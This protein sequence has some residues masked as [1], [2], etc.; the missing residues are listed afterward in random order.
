[1]TTDKDPHYFLPKNA[2]LPLMTTFAAL[3]IS[4][5]SRARYRWNQRCMSP[6]TNPKSS[7]W[8][9]T[10]VPGHAP[11][12]TWYPVKNVYG[13]VNIGSCPNGLVWVEHD[14]G[15]HRYAH[16]TGFSFSPGRFHPTPKNVKVWRWVTAAQAK[17][18]RRT[19]KYPVAKGT[20]IGQYFFTNRA[21]AGKVAGQ[22]RGYRLVQGT[23][24]GSDLL[25][26]FTENKRADTG[27]MGAFF[28]KSLKQPKKT[29]KVVK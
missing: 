11:S 1:M 12:P 23:L 22:F 20:L 21:Y 27:I 28:D 17:T 18:V 25:F 5:P 3:D 6:V 14:Q 4:K 15:D 8:T 10:K 9:W 2:K 13:S 7:A 29:F 24:S 26:Y 16:G 19:G